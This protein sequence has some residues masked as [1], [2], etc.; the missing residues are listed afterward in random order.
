MTT[1]DSGNKSTKIT[2]S[3]SNSEIATRD[4]STDVY[5]NVKG[6]TNK[7]SGKYYFEAPAGGV[8][9]D[10]TGAGLDGFGVANA[11]EA[12]DNHRPGANTNGI[13]VYV[14]ATSAPI[15]TGSTN[16]TGPAYNNKS[17]TLC[18][19][20][21]F[22]AK[23]VWA[24]VA[25]YLKSV[26]LC[27]ISGD[28]GGLQGYNLA[29]R[30]AK[31]AYASALNGS[32]V[33]IRVK[34]SSSTSD[35]G[36]GNT[37]LS[38]CYIGHPAASGDLYDFDGNQKQITF[39]GS[40]TLGL[41]V[42]AQ[43]FT[44]DVCDFSFD[45]TKDVIVR[46]YWYNGGGLGTVGVQWASSTGCNSYYKNT[47]TDESSV[48]N[49]STGYTADNGTAYFLDELFVYQPTATPTVSNWFGSTSSADPAA[50]TNGASFS[51]G[52]GPW[53]P[54]ACLQSPSSKYIAD[55]SQPFSQTIPSGFNPWDAAVYQNDCRFPGASTLVAG[56]TVYKFV[57]SA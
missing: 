26:K 37:A 17:D 8:C 7:N 5:A 31:T 53:Y 10:W 29:V 40:G 52:T 42:G 50:G 27:S 4:S 44:S 51:G 21:D 57:A 22:T 16:Q 2:S 15:L 55:F 35:A 49:A 25:S 41:G 39:I 54:V 6:T 3:G 9:A 18:L 30:I 32:A 36:S 34:T 23:L 14:N 1:W 56:G 47:G 45:A 19:A 38:G 13:A 46:F 28:A 48:T 20:Y 11:S 43:T 24:R 12:L 33:R